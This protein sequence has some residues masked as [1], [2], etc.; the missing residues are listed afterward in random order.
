MIDDLS[1][2]NPSGNTSYNVDKYFDAHYA[3]F[4]SMILALVK[5]EIRKSTYI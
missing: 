1:E 2:L 3:N 4:A 5:V